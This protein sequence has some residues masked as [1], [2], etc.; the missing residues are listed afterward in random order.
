MSPEIKFR[1]ESICFVWNSM[2]QDYD[3]KTE[4]KVI[5]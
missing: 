3:I 4:I 1:I 5:E 2:K